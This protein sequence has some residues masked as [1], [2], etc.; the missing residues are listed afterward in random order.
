MSVEWIAAY[1]MFGAFAIEALAS[2]LV[3]RDRRY[4]LGDTAVNLAIVV[5]YVAARVAI[6]AAVAIVLLAVWRVTPLRWSMDAWW[7]WVVL[8]VLEDFLYY[9]SHRASHTFRVLWASHVVHHNSPLV[10]LSTGLRN[11]WVGGAIDWVFFVP[12]AALGFHPLHIA[13]VIAVASAWD[14][15]THTPYI[16]KLRGIDWLMNSPSNH[17]VHHAKNREY[18]DKNFGGALIIWDRLFGTYAAETAPALFG[19]ERMPRRPHDPLHLQF[20]LWAE[21][22]RGEPDEQ[23]DHDDRDVLERAG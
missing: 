7:H 5:G 6:G 17:R 18:V 8:F 16:G 13:A 10:N 12:M 11:S 9:W 19:I 3:L 20:H 23:R 15:L 22:I 4:Q 2:H 14:F 21:L 1:V